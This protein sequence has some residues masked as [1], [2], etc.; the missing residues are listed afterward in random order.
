MDSQ[1]IQDDGFMGT[2]GRFSIYELNELQE[3][4]DSSP[5]T[6]VY[7]AGALDNS[8]RTRYIKILKVDCQVKGHNKEVLPSILHTTVIRP[9]RRQTTATNGYVVSLIARET[10]RENEI[11]Q[12]AENQNI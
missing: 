9:S 2:S 7:D 10:E 6:Q 1:V 3:E 8:A 4:R 5:G 12:D 11:S